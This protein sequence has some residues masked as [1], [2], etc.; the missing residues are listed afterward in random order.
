M[1]GRAQ[2][3]REQMR[4][5]IAGKLARGSKMPQCA[6]GTAIAAG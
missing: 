3:S 6:A 2:K 5:R 1:E 4:G